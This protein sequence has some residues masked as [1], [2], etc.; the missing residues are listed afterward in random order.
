MRS[1]MGFHIPQQCRQEPELHFAT[2]SSFH[3]MHEEE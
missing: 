1:T 2:F 3:Y